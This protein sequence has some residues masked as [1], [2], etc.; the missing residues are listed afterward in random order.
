MKL[1]D[2][3][4]I[5]LG[6]TLWPD[7]MLYDKQIETIYSIEEDDETYVSA[8]NKLGKDYVAG[9]IALNMFLRCIK[10]NK[11]CRIVSTS[12]AEHH[13]AVLWAE[14]SRFVAT[15]KYPLLGKDGGPLTMN[16]LELRRA[17]EAEA[18]NPINYLR[19]RVSAKGEGLAGHHAE[20]TLFIADEASGVDDES[21]K[22]AQGWAKRMLIF[23][24]PNPCQ[25][26]F[27]K[28]V[29]AGNMVAT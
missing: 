22:M 14:I 3:D 23:G 9:F 7:L 15:A 12:V 19:G 5:A 21:Y 13:L 20:V 11:T 6:Q 27:R 29:D 18:K 28:G 26:F 2:I 16:H 4:P 17:N 25:N 10:E 1:L 24:N 8:G